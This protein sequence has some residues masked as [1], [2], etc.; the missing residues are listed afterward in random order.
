MNKQL[1]VV[2]ANIFLRG[3]EYQDLC[4]SIEIQRTTGVI[5]LPP[6]CEAIVVPNDIEIKVEAPKVDGK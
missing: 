6:Y 5:V 1:L 2:R 4:R 3:K